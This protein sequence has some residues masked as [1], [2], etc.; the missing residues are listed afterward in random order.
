MAQDLLTC[1]GQ[2]VGAPAILGRQCLDPF[3][4][5]EPSHRAV[6]GTRSRLLPGQLFDVLR[7][8]ITVLGAVGQR[9][10]DV[11]A[12]FGKAAQRAQQVF[13]FLLRHT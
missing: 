8:R 3:P 13:V 12:G 10:Q 6:E 1:G 11:Q 5:F 4:R 9:D 7:D 2:P